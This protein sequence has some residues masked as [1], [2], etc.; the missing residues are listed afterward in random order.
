M[1]TKQLTQMAMALV[2]LIIC[3]QISIPLPFGV[4]FTLQVL[5]IIIIALLFTPKQSASILLLYLCMGILGFPVFASFSSGIAPFFGPTGGF[6]WSFPLMAYIISTYKKN[7]L[8]A[9][10]LGTMVT[11]LCGTLQFMYVVEVSF[12][13]S[14]QLTV[15]PFV[16]FDVCKWF[17]AKAI[18]LRIPFAALSMKQAKVGNE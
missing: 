1:N 7:F 11:Y 6:L 3:A 4:P 14:L 15:L 5:G 16:F 2:L 12:V 17:I 8:L 10:L 13:S 18:V 9:C